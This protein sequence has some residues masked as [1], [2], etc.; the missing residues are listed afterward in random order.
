M[1]PCLLQIKIEDIAFETLFIHQYP[2]YVSFYR[3]ITTSIIEKNSMTMIFFSSLHQ[4]Y[5][6]HSKE[7]R[8]PMHLGD[9]LS[10]MKWQKYMLKRATLSQVGGH[11][12]PCAP[13]GPLSMIFTSLYHQ[14]M[15]VLQKK[16]TGGQ[17]C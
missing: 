10:S 13:L 14:S 5:R 16:E 17:R 6:M 12:P 11:V 1:F 2:A 7:W 3:I 8:L 9:T 15:A 4:G